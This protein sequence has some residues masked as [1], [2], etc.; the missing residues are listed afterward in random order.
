MTKRN[1][2]VYIRVL[3]VKSVV[4]T[5]GKLRKASTKT[6]IFEATTVHTRRGD[7]VVNVPVGN[8]PIRHSTSGS[9]TPSKK[10]AWS[11]GV[12]QPDDDLPSLQLPKRSRTTGKVRNITM[13]LAMQLIDGHRRRTSF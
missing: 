10:R 4:T 11:P 13:D 7:A 6:R 2:T 5:M 3:Y 9:A 1:V 12:L 8:S